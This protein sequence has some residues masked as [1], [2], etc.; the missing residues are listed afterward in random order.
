MASKRMVHN[1]YITPGFADILEPS[2]VITE[3]LNKSTK[4]GNNYIGASSTGAIYRLP[5]GNKYIVR[6]TPGGIDYGMRL[7][8]ELDIY[9]KLQKDPVYKNYISD[10]VYGDV[11]LAAGRGKHSYFIFKYDNGEVLS[12]FI[13]SHRGSMNIN[14]IMGIY[15]H[16]LQAVNFLALHNVVHMDIKPENIYFSKDRGIPLLFDFDA[17]CEGSDCLRS[18]YSGSPKYST[19]GSKSIRGQEGFSTNTKMYMYSTIY[20][21]HALAIILKDDLSQLSKT[22]EIRERIK[23]IGRGEEAKYLMEND[24]L[25]EKNK[26]DGNRMRRNRTKKSGGSC[27]SGSCQLPQQMGG[28]RI[29]MMNPSFGGKSKRKTS[30]RVNNKMEALLNISES[31]MVGGG[32]GCG[33]AKPMMSLPPGISLGSLT[34]GLG[35]KG[36]GCGCRP[37]PPIPTPLGGGYRPTKRNIKYLKLWKKGKPI[38]FTMR[39]SLKAKGLIPRS[40]GTKHVSPKYK[41]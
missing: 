39:S 36:G 15:Q 4:E 14:E 12:D 21:K 9:K 26:K 30:K 28:Q 6:I 33:A 37:V 34:A 31:L 2:K 20:D 35:L 27:G 18:E 1:I 23:E 32:C 40:N 24:K 3:V 16:L 10:L 38:G 41:K 11:Y 22:A 13:K 29:A 8:K 17:S 19:P 5:D 25:Q 7:K